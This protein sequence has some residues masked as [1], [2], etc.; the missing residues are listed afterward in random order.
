MPD[1]TQAEL[2][3]IVAEA[4]SEIPDAIIDPVVTGDLVTASRVMA[5]GET[6]MPALVMQIDRLQDLIDRREKMTLIDF[7]VILATP[8]I[9]KN[10]TPSIPTMAL[11]YAIIASFLVGCHYTATKR[12][13]GNDSLDYSGFLDEH[14][15]EVMHFVMG[16]PRELQMKVA[17]KV[18]REYDMTPRTPTT[19]SI[20]LDLNLG[21]I[22]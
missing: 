12:D 14:L 4:M 6:L 2:D 11:M 9:A 20:T 17:L 7:G 10:I 21:D 13:T 18:M 22:L 3:A 15:P 19:D 16:M 8:R 1:M 5:L